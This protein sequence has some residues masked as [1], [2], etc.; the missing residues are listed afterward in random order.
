MIK[1]VASDTELAMDRVTEGLWYS[2][3]ARKAILSD[4]DARGLLHDR[5]VVALYGDPAWSAK[6]VS[7]NLSYEQTLTEVASGV[8]AFEIKPFLGEKSFEPV[9]RNG[10]Q[11]GWRPFV[12]FFPNRLEDIE[13]ITGKELSI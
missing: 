13:I 3:A 11:R 6:L 8:F 7:G 1:R 12:H 10:S 4:H 5:D 9:N 2:D